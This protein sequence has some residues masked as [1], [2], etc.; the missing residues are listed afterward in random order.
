MS[1]K[2]KESLRSRL[3][4][5][6]M[7]SIFGSVAVVTAS[8]IWRE[9]EQNG[10]AKYAELDASAQVFASAISEQVAL[11]N[12]Q[13][14]LNALRAISDIPSIEYVRVRDSNG[15][16]FVELGSTVAIGRAELEVEGG[17]RER[18]LSEFLFSKLAIVS[19]PIVRGGETVGDLALYSNTQ[20]LSERITQLLYDALVSAVFAAGIGILIALRMQ[21]TITDPI[22]G[23]AK[24]MSDVRE[25]GN[26]SYRAKRVRDDE[27]GELVDTFNNMLDQLQERDLKLQAHQKDLK[28]IVQRRTQ[29][30][31]NAKEVAEQANIAKSEFLAT[32]SHEI[33][34]P[35]NGMMVMA[36]LLTN[37]KL[38]PQHKRYAEVISKSGKSLIAIINDILD[39]SKIEAGRL[40][41]ESIS[42]RPTEVIDEI[43]SLYWEKAASKGI[44]LAGYVAP[45][46]PE[47]I[48]GDPIRIN[49]VL[50]NLVNN[51]L[52][53]TETG[54]VVV[55]V[56]R[57]PQKDGR[58]AIEFSVKDTGVG[59][60]APK[61]AAIFEA[62]SQADQ[63][64]TRRFGGTG[65]G[66]AI[67][68]R[69][70]EAMGG[71]IGLSSTPGKGSRFY[72]NFPTKILKPARK[73]RD[74]QGDK[75]AVIALDGSATPKMLARYIQET[76]I[77]AQVVP[78][79]G[80]IAAHIAYADM[81][82]ASPD[83][84]DAFH[85][86]ISGAP[87]QW[88]PTRI[89]VSEIGDTA[90]DRLIESGVA[91]DLLIAP[92]SRTDVLDQL[93]RI[94]DGNLRGRSALRHVADAGQQ[95][96]VYDQQEVLAADDS[97]VNRE[98]VKEALSKLNL[99]VTLAANGLEALR[100]A[101]KTRFSLI[102]M[103]C[104]MPEMDGFE[105]TRAI[106]KIESEKDLP[107]TPI[108]AL[109]AHV[110]GSDETW[111]KVGM[112]DYLTKPFTMESIGAVL[113]KH[114]GEPT[115]EIVQSDEETKTPDA[116]DRQPKT[117]PDIDTD[118]FDPAVLDQLAEMQAGGQ[119]L[120]ARAL[121]LY[122]EHSHA[123]MKRLLTSPKS[124]DDEEIAKAAHALKSMSL[125]VG[126]RRLAAACADIEIM[127]K[128]GADRTKVINGIKHAAAEYREV[129]A[130]LPEVL[131]HYEQRAA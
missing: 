108:V 38:S 55:S 119:N 75:R 32:M 21:R 50:S 12:R 23:L 100:A 63:T 66:L 24:I 62:F 121:T 33:R 18:E 19:V 99:N 49:Q 118:T 107:Q 31:Q 65:L 76:G 41:L 93:D 20:S 84:L 115:N 90:P 22:M 79:G 92:L 88:V 129:Q 43:I 51:A 25:S 29:E 46:A 37:A 122:K 45:N 117:S 80:A 125:N 14:T 26:F 131:T 59:I 109:T 57:A 95:Y 35:M 11:K 110:A 27:T 114:L 78:K 56:A 40:E 1:R 113:K 126:A 86:Q 13:E 89:C 16:L 104:S 83:F 7:I 47:V 102:L 15:E 3:T 44:D 124:G 74:V 34:T 97:I 130:M 101:R 127:A 58:F 5:L 28:T 42:V 10:A 112:N 52:K 106:R 105:A 61:Q 30:L 70:V 77:A 8:S 39:F 123:A 91:E 71:A 94:L 17:S 85:D 48:E 4:L 72:F 82:F 111:R 6:V 116:A 103:D 36:E 54:H 53:F 67:S 81:I 68:R 98:V 69:L 64:T 87:D 2:R 73:V 9:T 96:M 128:K 60:E 120:P